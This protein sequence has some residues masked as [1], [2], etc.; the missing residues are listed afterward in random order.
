MPASIPANGISTL[1]AAISS[2]SRNVLKTEGTLNNQIGLP[3][4]LLRMQQEHQ[5]AITIRQTISENVSDALVETGNENVIR[6][7]LKNTDAKISRS[8]ME[9]LVEQSK[10]V[11]TFQEPILRRRDLDPELVKRMFTWVSTVLRQLIV[12]DWD[13]DPAT[14]D[15]LLER[16]TAREV[17]AA[18]YD[19]RELSKSQHL[20]ENLD[21]VGKMTP[22]NM[23]G[24]LRE[25][26]V[27]LFISMFT[28]FTALD[29]TFVRRMLFEHG[30]NALAITCK[31]A[32]IGKAVFA[33]I[34]ALTRNKTNADEDS[35]RKEARQS[36]AIYNKTSREKAME[37]VR[38][39]QANNA[40]MN[41]LKR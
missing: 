28:K 25:G 14:V 16:A 33:S 22:E 20:A 27:A 26:E 17:Q 10:R 18:A 23:L 37:T 12:D 9:Y 41:A 32:G 8:T 3:L 29:E 24:V 30:G 4:T 31:A 5:L 6:S 15:D 7:L 36:L 11:D 13:L 38:R 19:A 2:R 34:F 35:L 40:A 39:W 1:A 21:A